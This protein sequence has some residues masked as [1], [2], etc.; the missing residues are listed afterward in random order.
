MSDYS[1]HALHMCIIM[2]E[3]ME[4]ET[5]EAWQAHLLVARDS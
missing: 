3:I 1:L 5:R 4:A 2:H